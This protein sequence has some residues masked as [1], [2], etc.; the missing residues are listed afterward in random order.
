MA[1]TNQDD[2]AAQDL[3]LAEAFAQQGN[4]GFSKQYLQFAAA[5]AQPATVPAPT[6]APT[7]APKPTTSSS[8]NIHAGS[9]AVRAQADDALAEGRRADALRL[10]KYA[11]DL[12]EEESKQAYAKGLA[13]RLAR[14]AKSGAFRAEQK[15]KYE[16]FE[17]GYLG[18]PLTP[19]QSPTGVKDM[20]G[21]APASEPNPEPELK[22]IRDSVTQQVYQG[23]V[24]DGQFLGVRSVSEQ[25][26][27]QRELAAR[28][29]NLPRQSEGVFYTQQGNA[30]LIREGAKKNQSVQ[31]TFTALGAPKNELIGDI[32]FSRQPQKT[33]YEKGVEF[34]TGKD[35]VKP[36]SEP[37]GRS[38]IFETTYEVPNAASAEFAGFPTTQNGQEISFPASFTVTREERERYAPKGFVEVNT[39]EPV[40]RFWE[41]VSSDL[42]KIDAAGIVLANQAR[43]ETGVRKVL[44]EA[45]PFPDAGVLVKDV[46]NLGKVSQIIGGT[47]ADQSEALQERFP[48]VTTEERERN[49]QGTGLQQLGGSLTLLERDVLSRVAVAGQGVG[50]F[51]EGE[52][53]ILERRPVT[54]GAGEALLV[55]SG[56]GVL[57][58]G[59]ESIRAAGYVQKGEIVLEKGGFIAR[60]ARTIGTTGKAAEIGA[61]IVLGGAFALQTIEE[62]HGA[63]SVR[64]AGERLA[65]PANELVGF[66]IGAKLGGKLFD[67]TKEGTVKTVKNIEKSIDEI[68]PGNDF[69]GK[70]GEVGGRSARER[71]GR[72]S[73]AE[74]RQRKSQRQQPYVLMKQDLGNQ[75]ELFTLQGKG[76]KRELRKTGE[77]PTQV[78]KT[79]SS[80]GVSFDIVQKKLLVDGER[81]T[82]ERNTFERPQ[83][84]QNL[85]RLPKDSN[86]PARLRKLAPEPNTDSEL[87]R[88]LLKNRQV[89]VKNFFSVL[90]EPKG[91]FAQRAP[92][93]D[94][95]RAQ[96]LV[97]PLELANKEQQPGPVKTEQFARGSPEDR[98]QRALSRL[99]EL[100]EARQKE[101]AMQ[102]EAAK[103]KEESIPQVKTEEDFSQQKKRRTRLLEE[104]GSKERSITERLSRNQFS[105]IADAQAAARKLRAI[106]KLSTGTTTKAVLTNLQFN[107]GITNQTQEQLRKLDAQEEGTPQIPDQGGRK[108]SSRRPREFTPQPRVDRIT[109]RLRTPEEPIKP[110]GVPDFLLK[111]NKGEQGYNVLVKRFGKFERVSTTALTKGQALATGERLVDESAS[112]TFKLVKVN[113]AASDEDA[114]GITNLDFRRKF[115][116][117]GDETYRERRGR[118]LIDTSGERLDITAKGLAAIKSKRKGLRV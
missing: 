110:I 11:N 49:K 51:I 25:E 84:V 103:V 73:K 36:F 82:L 67:V 114:S 64:I 47:I 93:V 70:R 57:G 31:E 7:P 115:K 34:I 37:S 54:A 108:E 22:T 66:G 13:D 97:Q 111:K 43:S 96:R 8:D 65:Q 89:Q 20:F 12:R 50:G 14:Q 88:L 4:Q 76:V 98:K 5:K 53:A 45:S 100:Q 92:F 38:K 3:R 87:Q 23:R 2:T 83:E 60:A 90:K 107:K 86:V 18:I 1:S 91:E 15:A 105:T 75:Q 78:L 69:L 19:E 112:Q 55:G 10:R 32:T 17:P 48:L 16:K 99:R 21:Q 62:V 56:F 117:L 116:A 52:G 28:M 72:T 58:R 95:G 30:V 40:K 118:G 80:E 27:T 46:Q 94:T 81:V 35:I 101:L 71:S 63:P 61:G 85:R 109:D 6:S 33:I 39:P 9:E 26:Q 44:R 29:A 102:A 77:V 104:Q 68:Q 42:N 59:I 113:Q 41:G 24:S 106:P 79:R 74:L